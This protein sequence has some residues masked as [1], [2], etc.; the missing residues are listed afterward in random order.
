MQTSLYQIKFKDDSLYNIFCANAKQN[1]DMLSIITYM[2]IHGGYK[3]SKV[4]N[5]TVLCKGIHTFK[6]FNDIIK[7]K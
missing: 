3:N 1:K 6:Q 4:K 7:L 2:N 5:I